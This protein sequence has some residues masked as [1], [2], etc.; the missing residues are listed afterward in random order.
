M[1]H[2]SPFAGGD[3]AADSCV[4]PLSSLEGPCC[5]FNAFD[6]QGFPWA[7]QS[8]LPASVKFNLLFYFISDMPAAAGCRNRADSASI[9]LAGLLAQLHS[10][11]RKQL[12]SNC[13][14]LV[15]L[16]PLLI[17]ACIC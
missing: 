17:D 15:M 7:E 2:F 1:C 12:M 11:V 9:S 13:L 16:V 14:F 6:L 8:C 4:S 10:F 3:S 5:G